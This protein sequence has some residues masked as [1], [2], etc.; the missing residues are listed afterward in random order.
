[1]NEKRIEALRP[2]YKFDETSADLQPPLFEFDLP[3]AD[4]PANAHPLTFEEI[5]HRESVAV[6]AFQARLREIVLMSEIQRQESGF[7]GVPGYYEVFL[8]LLDGGWPPRVAAFI[9][10]SSSPRLGRW[11]KTQDDLAHMLGLTSDRQF[12]KWRRASPAIDALIVKLQAEPLLKHRADVF[13]ALVA[14]ASDPSYKNQ[15]DRKL[16]L[17]IT[18]DYMPTAKFEAE[19]KKS[20]G[21][22]LAGESDAALEQLVG[23][24]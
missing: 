21:N 20:I 23:G 3:P 12:T 24:Q 7:S 22:G 10:W 17:E 14:S 5:R 11:P 13:A 16:L 9:A 4:Q 19:L 6:S 1:M 2:N 18:G 8:D 15:P